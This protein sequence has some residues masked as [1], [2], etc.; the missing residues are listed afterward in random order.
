MTRVHAIDRSGARHELTADPDGSLMEVL[1]D[2]GLGVEAVCGGCCSC[3]TCHVH[4]DADW[5][6]LVGPPGETESELLQ[7]SEYFDAK[8]SRLS[9]QI[10]CAAAIDGLVVTVAPEE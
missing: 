1:R 6:D 10:Q 8:R 4:V 2:Q 3:A 5:C 9:C 7:I